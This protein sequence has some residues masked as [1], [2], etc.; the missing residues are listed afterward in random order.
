VDQ[1]QPGQ[2]LE[3]CG[4]ATKAASALH[5]PLS[6]SFSMCCKPVL[7]RSKG[8]FQTSGASAA[9]VECA[10]HREDQIAVGGLVRS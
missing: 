9:L 4:Q 5:S 1:D 2:V 3:L 10:E 7:H 8:K 6:F